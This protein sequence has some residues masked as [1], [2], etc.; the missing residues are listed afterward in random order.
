MVILWRL[1]VGPYADYYPGNDNVDVL[2]LDAYIGFKQEF[3]DGLLALAGDKPVAL[4]EVGKL[5]TPAV[6]A[7]Q[8]RWV[9]FL[10]WNTMLTGSNSTEAIQSLYADPRTLTRDRVRLGPGAAP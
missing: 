8:P 4:G 6:L 5:P 3:Y 10:E 2:G 7:A 1:L 9:Y